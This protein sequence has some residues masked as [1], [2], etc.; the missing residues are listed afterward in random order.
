MRIIPRWPM[1]S[2]APGSGA[3]R[4]PVW[5]NR[6]GKKELAAAKTARNKIQLTGD[7]RSG[8][9]LP[10]ERGPFRRSHSASLKAPKQKAVAFACPSDLQTNQSSDVHSLSHP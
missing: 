7:S 5:G 6:K 9:L 1:M 3:P 2:F 4:K 8:F 10:S